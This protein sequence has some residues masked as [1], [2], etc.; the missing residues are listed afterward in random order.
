MKKLHFFV[1]L[2]MA[3]LILTLISND[4]IAG[5]F[6]DNR[7][8]CRIVCQTPDYL[9]AEIM[10]PENAIP[11]QAHSFLVAIPQG[12]SPELKISDVKFSDNCKLKN[13]DINIFPIP[14]HIFSEFTIRGINLIEIEIT[15]YSKQTEKGEINL[16][17][18]I[19]FQIKFIGG[20]KIFCEPRIRSRWWDA[21]IKKMVINFSQMPQLDYKIPGNPDDEAEYLIITPD[22]FS[23]KVEE[24]KDFRILQGITT[25]VVTLTEIGGNTV[26]LIKNYISDA[27]NF[28]NIP[29]AAVLL[30]GDHQQIAA[31]VW[32]GYCASDNI[33]VD[34]SG[35]DLPDMA[36]ARIPVNTLTELGT[37]IDRVI[38]YETEP[39]DNPGFYDHPVTSM[40]WQNVSR[41]MAVTE[42]INGWF[43]FGMGKNPVRENTIIY[44]TPGT[45]WFADDLVEVFGPDG[46]GYI[47]A[48]PEHLTDWGGNAQRINNDLNEGAFVLLNVDHG[49]TTGWQHPSYQIPDLAGLSTADP[50]LLISINNLNGNF[51]SAQDCMA[52]A[53][54]KNPHGGLGVIAPSEVTYSSVNEYYLFFFIDGLWENFIPYFPKNQKSPIDFI[55][56]GFANVYA[57]YLLSS[58]GIIPPNTN[59]KI[60][61][62]HLFHYFGE[63]FTNMYDTIPQQLS[64][65]HS[66][67]LV[68][69]Q[70]QI[71]ITA[72][73]NA[74]IALV[75]NE[76]ICALE[77]STGNTLQMSFPPV[78]EGDTL[79]ITATKQNR[80]RY[81]TELICSS[82]IG[83][84]DY[85]FQASDIITGVSLSPNPAS[86]EINLKFFVNHSTDVEIVI[87]SETGSLISNVFKGYLTKGNS[88][89]IIK[90]S[91]LP[92]GLYFLEIKTSQGRIVK[93]ILK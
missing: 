56:P 52:E 37:V 81:H 45:T 21:L 72:E 10:I 25:K 30:L 90:T 34:V 78:A 57:K 61:T 50:A 73:E 76:E 14:V 46:L 75:L 82:N 32:Q 36:I 43:E 63:T 7:I 68:P 48:T 71:E 12:A 89:Y 49:N 6:K 29:P 83:I 93:K 19:R 77:Q 79:H 17:S 11:G 20:S 86:E 70:D 55:L 42:I 91:T 59:A 88:S 64:I 58:A 33:Y 53:F 22:I 3:F 60:A 9:E 27:Y 4:N 84:S 40:G 24:L 41:I 1:K 44:G 54:L 23:P 2:V 26:E 85:L 69:G 5:N 38:Q 16:Y 66:E 87:I 31:P 15:P 65:I 74:L 67:T 18:Y 8:I 39:P 62:Y 80:Y 51:I 13:P 47:P 92:A 28:W 35:N